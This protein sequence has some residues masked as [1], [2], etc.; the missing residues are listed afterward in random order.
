[1]KYNITPYHF[2]D[3]AKPYFSQPKTVWAISRNEIDAAFFRYARS[4]D[5]KHKLYAGFE[6]AFCYGWLS[7]RNLNPDFNQCEIVE[8]N[9]F[10]VRE[11]KKKG[12]KK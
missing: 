7:S 1:M 10:T 12:G 2:P 4:Q 6:L 8:Q 11:I 5:R 9:N 3:P